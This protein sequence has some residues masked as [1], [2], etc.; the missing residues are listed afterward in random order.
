MQVQSVNNQNKNTNFGTKVVIK[1]PTRKLLQTFPKKVRDNIYAQRRK[2]MLNGIDDVLTIS[3]DNNDIGSKG[4]P[5]LC[6][7][8]K[9][10]RNGVKYK[11]WP[12]NDGRDFIYD[13]VFNWVCAPEPRIAN[14]NNIYLGAVEGAVPVK[15]HN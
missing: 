4:Q 3:H 1:R 11:T 8:V 5:F 10:V 13:T 14:L 7:W 6:G 15:L 9:F 2:L 12:V